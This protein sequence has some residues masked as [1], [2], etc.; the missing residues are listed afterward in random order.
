MQR[1]WIQRRGALGLPWWSRWLRLHVQEAWVQSLVRELRSHVARP[2]ILK[3]V[4]FKKEVLGA[5]VGRGKK[6]KNKKK[7]KKK[8]WTY[9][10]VEQ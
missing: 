7:I 6:I 5:G 8:C 1:P 4:S 10:G 3:Q 2:K 9:T